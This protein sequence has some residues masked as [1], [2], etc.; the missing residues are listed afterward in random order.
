MKAQ[1][2]L[3]SVVSIISVQQSLE[4]QEQLYDAAEGLFPVTFTVMCSGKCL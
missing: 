4:I 3:S 2:R 1:E